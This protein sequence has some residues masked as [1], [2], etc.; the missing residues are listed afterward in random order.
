[1]TFARWLFAICGI[2]GIIALAPLY[3]M[4]TQLGKDYPPPITHPE[5]FYANIGLALVWQVAFLVISRDPLRFRPLMLV[6]V[7]EKLSYGVPAAI[8]FFQG[9]SPALVLIT[10]S[11]DL[12]MGVLFLIAY[13]RTAAST[14]SPAAEVKG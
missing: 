12:A 8:L 13:Q 10:G 11:I 3:F 4:E 6:G 1:M 9:R 5:F 14:A 7:L 2:Y